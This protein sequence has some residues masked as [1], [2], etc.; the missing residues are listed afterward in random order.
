MCYLRIDVYVFAPATVSRTGS[1]TEQRSGFHAAN[2]ANGFCVAVRRP[3][4][5][6]KRPVHPLRELR[7]RREDVTDQLDVRAACQRRGVSCVS[8]AA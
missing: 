6:G 3:I 5:G 8:T 7:A 2:A 1:D 4:V